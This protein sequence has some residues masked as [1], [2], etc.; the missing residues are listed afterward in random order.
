LSVF[1]KF[2]TKIKEQDCL[3]KSLKGLG[4][5]PVSNGSKQ[6]VRGHGS[7]KLHGDVVLLKEDTKLKGDIGFDKQS[8][9]TYNLV[10]DSYVLSPPKDF[11]KNVVDGYG[12]AKVKK[13]MLA[14]PNF[15]LIQSKETDGTTKMI[16]EEVGA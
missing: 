10:Y 6:E 2:Q 7:E 14:F 1:R 12:K 5:N 13:Q 3:E 15:R 4:Y 11:L 9:G 16:F 8:D